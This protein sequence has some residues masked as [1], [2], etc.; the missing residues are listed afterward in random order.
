MSAVRWATYRFTVAPADRSVIESQGW[1]YP[2]GDVRLSIRVTDE[3]GGRLTGGGSG[4]RV[5]WTYEPEEDGFIIMEVRSTGDPGYYVYGN[6][7]TGAPG[8]AGPEDDGA[9]GNQ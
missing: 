5:R 7:E 4:A 8:F 1:S 2:P 3:T 9:S 6:T